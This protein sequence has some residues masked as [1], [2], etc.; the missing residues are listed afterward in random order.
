MKSQIKGDFFKLD[1]KIA[2]LLA[3]PDVQSLYGVTMERLIGALTDA[4]DGKLCSCF[5]TSLLIPQV[6]DVCALPK[7]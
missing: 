6:I 5:C 7:I 4:R 2:Q 1:S 3:C